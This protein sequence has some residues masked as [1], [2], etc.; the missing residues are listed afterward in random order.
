MNRLLNG[1]VPAAW[2]RPLRGLFACGCLVALALGLPAA[3]RAE[4]KPAG[5]LTPEQQRLKERAAALDGEADK[6]YQQ[7]QYAESTK[8]LQEALRITEGLYPKDQYPQG[9]P[10]L[11]R[12]LNNL[13]FFLQHQGEYARAPCVSG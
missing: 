3:V 12:R 10:D 11:A 8:L 6:L 9:H 7:G 13:G 1:T 5:E 2:R 4:D